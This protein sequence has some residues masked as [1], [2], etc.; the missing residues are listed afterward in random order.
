MKKALVVLLVLAVVG[1]ASFADVKWSVSSLYGFGVGT[2]NSGNFVLGYDYSQVGGSR[3]R[4]TSKITSDDGNVGFTARFEDTS[5]V[6][7]APNFN[8]LLGWAKLFNGMLTI[9]AGKLDDYTISLGDWNCFGS[10]DNGKAGVLFDVTPMAGLDIAFIQQITGT[11]AGPDWGGV[12]GDI[13][14][15]KFALPNLVTVGGGA[16][17]NLS[18]ATATTG[19]AAY[20]FFAV[21]AVP[22]LTFNTEGSS[23][24]ST[25]T[26]PSPRP[27]TLAIRWAP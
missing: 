12:N 25:G 17:L 21:T 9:K 13:V 26:P 16:V 15:A 7:A 24:S 18:T 10:Q 1:V 4:L 2:N 22:G 5:V 14:G 20:V 3:L 19:N 6:S 8:Q 27:R 23:S 11:L